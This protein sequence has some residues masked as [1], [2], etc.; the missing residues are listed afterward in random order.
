MALVED[1][2]TNIYASIRQNTVLIVC[3][4]IFVLSLSYTLR[5]IMEYQPVS[6][7]EK[8]DPDRVTLELVRAL[9]LM[10]ASGVVILTILS[11]NIL[12]L[13]RLNRH[14]HDINKRLSRNV[15]AVEACGDGIAILD[16]Q[17]YY[18]FVNEAHAQC[19]GYSVHELIGKSWRIL[20]EPSRVT[21]LE[22][23][24][25]PVLKAHG[26][27]RGRDVGRKKDGS[28]FPQ[29]LR[30][31]MLQGG[32]FVCVVRDISEKVRNENLLKMI[33]VAVEAAND[34]IAITDAENRLLFMN[35][36]FLT[37]H[38][39]NPFERD[40]YIG[41]D[42]RALY[43]AK[44]QEQINSFVLPTTILKGAWSGFLPVM[45]KDGTV[46]YGD[47]SLTK[48][49]DGTVLGVMRDVSERHAAELERE[50][51][52][53]QLFQSQKME[54]IGRLMQGMTFDFNNILTAISGYAQTIYGEA[55]Q[56]GAVRSH[57]S[58]INAACAEAKDL[59]DQLTAFS[60]KKDL[61]MP[62][63]DLNKSLADM[64]RSLEEIIPAN[65]ETVVNVQTEQAYITGQPVQI[66]QAIRHL[67]ANA[68]E[69]IGT[70]P[71]KVAI[72]LKEADSG[73]NGIR[74]YVAA[75]IMP[76]RTKAMICRYRETRSRS[77]LVAGYAQNTQ[78]YFH[79]TVS[80]TGAGIPKEI[81]PNIFDP[82]FSTKKNEKSAGLGLYSVLGTII[83][84]N[85]AIVVETVVGEGTS[86]HFF[87]PKADVLS[88][89]GKLAAAG[90]NVA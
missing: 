66:D 53:E 38:G 63:M 31:N 26:E 2:E 16:D 6:T 14:T 43:N 57:V 77:Y 50:D 64:Q 76:D 47:A 21:W 85:G 17:G 20:Y 33:K 29:E 52:R 79:M 55:G 67:I 58:K 69:S 70:K 22:R 74:R 24:A 18:T 48:L 62:T 5:T 73:V 51:L 39:Y 82:F 49:P 56:E 89:R 40:K 19:Y 25:F 8:A 46:F 54:A 65:I 15:E 87:L 60:R 34:G 4:A 11:G 7:Y 37:I 90:L 59:V 75:D 1:G 86:F 68:V 72:T 45:K 44:G 61:K 35:R 71:G 30:L 78:D 32:G 83:G 42:W 81:L 41:T 23:E 9:Y 12:N 10:G 84:Y 80:D 27:W 28:E 88:G 36:S 3:A 13:Y